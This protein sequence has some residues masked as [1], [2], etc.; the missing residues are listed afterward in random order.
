MNQSLGVTWRSTVL[1]SRVFCYMLLQV[2]FKAFRVE[3]QWA[4]VMN[5]PDF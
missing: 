4:S 2:L 1:R 5:M 3:G